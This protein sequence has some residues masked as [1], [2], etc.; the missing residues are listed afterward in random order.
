MVEYLNVSPNT[1]DAD[2]QVKVLVAH[3]VKLANAREYE[4]FR[5]LVEGLLNFNRTAHDKLM[6]A[7]PTH[8]YKD[9]MASAPAPASIN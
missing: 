4:R 5:G 2:Y 7:I 9:I 3:A 6:L 1:K 8:V